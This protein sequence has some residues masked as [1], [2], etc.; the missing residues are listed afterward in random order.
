MLNRGEVDT[1]PFIRWLIDQEKRVV[2]P[3]IKNFGASSN[4]E[5]GLEHRCFTSET[6]L[7]QNQWGVLEPAE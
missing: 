7:R 1:R 3:V 2:M 5:A 4:T 6:E